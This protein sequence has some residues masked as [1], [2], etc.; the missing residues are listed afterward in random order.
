[1]DEKFSLHAEEKVARAS[2]SNM[3]PKLNRLSKKD[4]DILFKQGEGFRTPLVSIR[5]RPTKL[6]IARFCILFTKAAKLSSVERNAIRRQAYTMIREHLERFEKGR[7]YGI[8]IS[9][10]LA[11]YESAKRREAL[12]KTF[13]TL[14]S[15]R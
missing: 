2:L 4:I 8:M 12:G 5:T 3:L 6:S 1:M 11:H 14:T 10:A 15:P 7:D 9:P 13:I